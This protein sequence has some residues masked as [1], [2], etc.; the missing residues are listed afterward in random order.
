MGYIKLKYADMHTISGLTDEI[1]L[2]FATKNGIFQTA[3][4]RKLD[5]LGQNVEKIKVSSLHLLPFLFSTYVA[6]SSCL[7]TTAIVKT[8]F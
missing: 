3:I 1:L 2:H 4:V 6:N 8:P 5:E 7:C